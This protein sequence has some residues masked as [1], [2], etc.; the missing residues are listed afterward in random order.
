MPAVSCK[1]VLVDKCDVAC[2]DDLMVA[3]SLRLLEDDE[4]RVRLAVG[5]LL[6]ALAGKHGLSVV[7][8]CQETL[9]GSITNH[10]VSAPH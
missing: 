7:E 3:E 9:L 2:F 6:R 1:Q 4:V 8:A 10:F 5:Q